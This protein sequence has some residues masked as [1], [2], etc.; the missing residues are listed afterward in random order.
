M[1]STVPQAH[2]G[3]PSELRSLQVYK[4]A[5]VFWLHIHVGDETVPVPSASKQVSGAVQATPLQR[6]YATIGAPLS[7]SKQ[8]K[9]AAQSTAPHIH[10]GRVV[11]A[12]SGSWQVKGAVQVTSL[13]RH[14]ATNA[15]VGSVSKQVSGATHAAV[16]QTQTGAI[17]GFGSS[18]Q[19]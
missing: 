13:Q 9:G 11:P 7:V 2:S 15:V 4:A 6:H 5:Q 19:V 8:V 16:L 1:H 14:Y 17:V 18:K 10:E 3:I 12:P